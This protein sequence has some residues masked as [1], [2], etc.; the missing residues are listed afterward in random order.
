M[1]RDA[2]AAQV[3]LLVR[4]LPFIADEEV[5]ALKGGTAINLFYRDM[6]RLSVDIDLTYLPVRDRAES[7]A[8]IDETLDR[9]VA[10]ASRGIPRLDARRI[11]GG[12][13]GA[14]RIKARLD[15]AE[16]KIETSP[17]T[18]GVVHDPERR[19]VSAAVED[20]FGYASIQVVS[21]ED[22]FGGKLHA[23]VDRQHPRDLFDVKLLY[24]NEGFTDALFRT[25][26]VYVASSP[27]PAHELLSP[28][29]SKLDEPFAREFVGMTT[30]PVT[31]EELAETRDRLFA[32]LRKRMDADT[33][34]FL[35]SLHEG[36]PDF[37]AI[38]LP[39]AA[40][41]PAVRWKLLNLNK[42][43]AENPEKH[44]AHREELEKLFS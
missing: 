27:R 25:F 37:E 33:R 10:A 43:S 4:L 9:I 30:V 18:R 24:E 21:F 5:F 14:T 32:D 16:V 39:Q 26:L 40:S 22:L 31:L 3:A 1:A 6:P 41:L 13:G 23:A 7:L 35:T 38:G 19:E 28:G 36:E 34:R 11:E 20:E 8:D 29:L 44:K 2:Y 42:L 12:G 17:V 15:G